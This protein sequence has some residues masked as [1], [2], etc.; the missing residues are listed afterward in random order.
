MTSRLA[1]SEA[2][3]FL[4]LLV[5]SCGRGDSP[6][7]DRAARAWYSKDYELA[8][9]EYERYLERYPATERSAEARLQ[10]ANIYYLNLRRYDRAL[11]HYREFL[12]QN[13]SHP[14]SHLARE[15][16]AEVLAEMGR[17]YEAIAE[18]EN[19]QPKDE[20]DRRRIRLLIADLYFKQ[21]NYSQ[22]LTE[23]DK[24]IAG[25]NYD[26]LSERA[27]LRQASIYHLAREQYQQALPVYRELAL[28]SP[29]PE[30]RRRA[31]Y[32][33]ADCYAGLYDFDEA[34]K[35]LSQIK[36]PDQQKYIS[37]RIAELEQRKRDIGRAPEMKPRSKSD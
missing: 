9:E 12:N 1:I 23:Y 20:L 33:M 36:D 7:L 35:T 21:Q 25:A 29:D 34:I 14:E 28:R 3:L 10:L 18:Y 11:T 6:S 15:R 5:S 24:V 30:V 27:Y 16:L 37:E 13:P 19:L 2:A 32:G 8:A 4:A 22:A 26:Y 17:L 31:I